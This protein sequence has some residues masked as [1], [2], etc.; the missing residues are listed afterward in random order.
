MSLVGPRPLTM[1]EVRRLG[2]HDRRFEWRF[3]VAQGL[4]GPVQV[5]GAVSASDSAALERAYVRRGGVDT[6]LAILGL[7]A[8]MFVAGRDRVQ[9]VVRSRL[10]ARVA[11]WSSDGDVDEGVDGGDL[12][13]SPAAPHA[14]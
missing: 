2:W 14:S 6:D 9:R 13:V 5:L 4:T 7:T 12:G 8:V 11:A 1:S 10:E 3:R